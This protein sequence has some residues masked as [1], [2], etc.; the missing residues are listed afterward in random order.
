MD[1]SKASWQHTRVLG[2][3]L[4]SSLGELERHA[5][6]PL[7]LKVLPSPC[8]LFESL[9]D[10]NDVGDEARTRRHARPEPEAVANF[11]CFLR[12]SANCKYSLLAV[13]LEPMDTLLTDTASALTSREPRVCCGSHR[14][15]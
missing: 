9:D 12:W 7:L 3:P 5:F 10:G 13:A 11:D 8:L 6:V 15:K 14:E 2:E 4:A 1:P